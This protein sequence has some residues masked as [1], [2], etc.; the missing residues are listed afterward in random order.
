MRKHNKVAVQRVA[1]TMHELYETYSKIAKWKTNKKCKDKSFY[2]L[3]KENQEVMI[4]M[5]NWVLEVE[6]VAKK[7]TVDN[8]IELIN[9]WKYNANSN[10]AQALIT[11]LKLKVVK[12][13]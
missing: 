1:E 6:R 10:D 7:D 12:I 3:P 2:E 5:A 11:W 13:K 4:K 9:E 8:V